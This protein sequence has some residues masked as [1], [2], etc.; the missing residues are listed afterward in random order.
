MNHVLSILLFLGMAWI[1]TF[2]AVLLCSLPAFFWRRA[3]SFRRFALPSGGS[4]GKPFVREPWTVRRA[5]IV[6]L[7][8]PFGLFFLVVFGIPLA[9][10]L[11]L[12]AL[13]VSFRHHRYLAYRVLR[14]RRF[15]LAFLRSYSVGFTFFVAS[16]FRSRRPTPF[17]RTA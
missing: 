9:L 7:V 1:I 3:F 4:A 15:W 5:L 13:C 6:T 2:I 16:L 17:T 10:G 11:A 12:V 8:A 14:R